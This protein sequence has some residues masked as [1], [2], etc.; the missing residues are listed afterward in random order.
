MPA[1]SEK[2]VIFW[3]SPEAHGSSPCLQV[4]CHIWPK[5]VGGFRIEPG[6]PGICQNLMV[7]IS[8]LPNSCKIIYQTPAQPLPV[9]N[10]CHMAP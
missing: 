8:I 3:G 6:E 1:F 2:G 10:I 9:T 7:K 5:L 4:E